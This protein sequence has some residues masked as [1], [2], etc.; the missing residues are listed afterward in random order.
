MTDI[1]NNNL[2][3]EAVKNGKNYNNTDFRK[4]FRLLEEGVDVNAQDKD[5]I[6]ALMWAI[7][8]GNKHIVE[9]LL[10][11]GADPN[12]KDKKGTSALT[13][14]VMSP[15]RWIK[16]EIV[17]ILLEKGADV[18]AVDNLGLTPVMWAYEPQY[19]DPDIVPMLQKKKK[20]VRDARPSLKIDM[21]MAMKP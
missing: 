5:G 12:V 2:L 16:K 18:N 3:I 19:F 20:E 8:K 1:N 14:S 11:K 9:M 15:S 7:F 13:L 21:A 4:I 6:T 10:K 17:S